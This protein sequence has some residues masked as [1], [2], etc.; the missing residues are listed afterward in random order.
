MSKIKSPS[1]ADVIRLHSTGSPTTGSSGILP[2]NLIKA[3]PTS[4]KP[5]TGSKGILPDDLL[6]VKT[7]SKSGRPKKSDNKKSHKTND[8]KKS[9]SPP[10]K[11]DCGIIGKC[12]FC[13]T[14]LVCSISNALGLA[15]G[16]SA[17]SPALET[18]NQIPS[19]EQAATPK[20]IPLIP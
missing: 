17:G 14:N 15:S 9:S 5:T 10:A 1:D 12:P 19:L 16:S 20:T 3:I 18:G 13:I 6:K 11:K 8:S 2:E 7:P 4:G